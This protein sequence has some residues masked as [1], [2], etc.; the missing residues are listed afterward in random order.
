MEIMHDYW[1][2]LFDFPNGLVCVSVIIITPNWK[3][4]L[5]LDGTPTE[6]GSNKGNQTEQDKTKLGDSLVYAT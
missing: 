5:P 4:A 6:P 2:R 3:L 1:R